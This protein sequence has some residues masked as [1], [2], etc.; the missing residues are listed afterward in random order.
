MDLRV[1]TCFDLASTPH[2]S[3][4]ERQSV[5]NLFLFPSHFCLGGLPKTPASM[6]NIDDP[7]FPGNSENWPNSPDYCTALCE[8]AP[9]TPRPALTHPKSMEFPVLGCPPNSEPRMTTPHPSAD[10]CANPSNARRAWRRWRTQKLCIGQPR[11]TGRECLRRESC[12]LDGLQ[13][14]QCASG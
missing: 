5:L 7:I 11:V 8:N 3:R 9:F 13:G 12:H 2:S 14:P 1:H 10:V 6:F 4:C